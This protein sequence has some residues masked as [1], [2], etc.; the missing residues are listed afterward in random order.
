LQ[1]FN[2][3]ICNFSNDSVSNNNLSTTDGGVGTLSTCRQTFNSPTHP[4][5]LSTI[6]TQRVLW[7][8]TVSLL[9]IISLATAGTIT[10]PGDHELRGYNTDKSHQQEPI[11]WRRTVNG[12]EQRNRWQMEPLVI[13]PAMVHPLVVA[14]L[15]G[16]IS[17]G[18]LVA[19]SPT[20]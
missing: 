15:M 11:Q 12:W 4:E 13:A 8:T 14:F 2:G 17:L 1:I 16:F 6:V 3:V 7:I 9:L 18:A 5:K 10:G 19:L 20:G